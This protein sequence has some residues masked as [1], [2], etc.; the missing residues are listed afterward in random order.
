MN[1]KFEYLYRDF[2]NYKN[3]GSVTVSNK[4][5]LD[6]EDIKNEIFKELIDQEYFYAEIVDIPLLYFENQNDDDHNL[7]E[8]Y[9]I[10]LSVN[11]T[12]ID[13]DIEDILYRLSKSKTK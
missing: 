6:L 10:S 11:E 8:F 4:N 3:Y 13:G 5:S 12:D 1:I 2:A 7:H 9:N